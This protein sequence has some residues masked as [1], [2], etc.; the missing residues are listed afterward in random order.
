MTTQH[1]R[2]RF[3]FTRGTFF[4]RDAEL[5]LFT[6]LTAENEQRA[7]ITRAAILFFCRAIFAAPTFSGCTIL[8]EGEGG[9]QRLWFNALLEIRMEVEVLT[10]G[11]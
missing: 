11:G 2:P 4:T 9:A 6:L 1:F 10:W 5:D 7:T 3:S 8:H